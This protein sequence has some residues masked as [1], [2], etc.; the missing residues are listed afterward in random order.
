MRRVRTARSRA[1]HGTRAKPSNNEREPAKHVY[2]RWFNHVDNGSGYA[3]NGPECADKRRVKQPVHGRLHDQVDNGSK[4]VGNGPEYEKPKSSEYWT[5]FQQKIT[6]P[7]L[8]P[9]DK[10]L[11]PA[12]TVAVRR[13]RSSPLACTVAR[14]LIRVLTGAR[15]KPIGISLEKIIRR[16]EK[17]YLDARGRPSTKVT[18]REARRDGADP[19]VVCGQLGRIRDTAR[20]RNH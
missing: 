17:S 16:P 12:R 1:G 5:F 11:G 15:R 19:Y 20:V 4:H 6:F 10:N 13:L 14:Y 3:G 9:H 8:R 7:S 2:V 18:T